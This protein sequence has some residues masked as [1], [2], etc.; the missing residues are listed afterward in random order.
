MPESG[1]I[2]PTTAGV[3]PE[4]AEALGIPAGIEALPEADDNIPLY[5]GDDSPGDGVTQAETAFSDADYAEIFRNPP[6]EPPIADESVTAHPGE[7]M[8]A[9]I[10]ADDTSRPSGDSDLIPP[11]RRERKKPTTPVAGPPSL[12]DWQDFFS[13]II[14][15]FL[16]E[17]YVDYAFRGVDDSIVTDADLAKI[18]L[19]KEDREIIARPFS[20]YANK[21]PWARKHGREIVALAD[22]IESLV[23][24]GTWVSRVNRVSRKYKPKHQ[25]QPRNGG[26]SILSSNFVPRRETANEPDVPNEATGIRGTLNGR[27]HGGSIID[28]P[29][30]G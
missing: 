20:E 24:L 8:D 14:I 22:S 16:C 26:A 19:S 4:A 15:R 17:W 3:T 25:R 30:G 18:T 7:A 23:I 9:A 2:I 10:G 29:G 28:N 11:E 1:R 21:N 27:I 12:S 6:Y 13:R 5:Y